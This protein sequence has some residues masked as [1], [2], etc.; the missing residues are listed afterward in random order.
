VQDAGA[1]H[2]AT[3]AG[4]TNLLDNFRGRLVVPSSAAVYG[5]RT[6]PA[7]ETDPIPKPVNAYAAAKL[8]TEDFCLRANREGADT[9]IL[10]IFTGYGP[11]DWQKKLA[12]SPATHFLLSIMKSQSPEVFGNGRQV[13][14]FV[15]VDDIARAIERALTT[16]S[17]HAVFNVGTGLATTFLDLVALINT[18]LGKRIAPR[19][20]NPPFPTV[21]TSCADT[22][23]AERELGFR[24]V[25]ILP[26]GMAATLRALQSI[27]ALPISI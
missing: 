9:R 8:E 1:A 22:R 17:A 27:E 14:D 15:F 21:A 3:I 16:E 13:R 20:V 23:L 6:T 24:A 25:T 11:H 10:R 7:R 5:N 12:A 26:D 4:I 19:F 18:M 2:R